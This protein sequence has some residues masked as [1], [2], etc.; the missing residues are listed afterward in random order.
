MLEL[1]ASILCQMK[2][3]LPFF[4]SQ[5][6]KNCKIPSHLTIADK[7]QR[8]AAQAWAF[9]VYFKNHFLLCQKATRKQWDG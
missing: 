1:N 4:G 7:W 8:P 2:L 9:E 6:M 5:L 3:S